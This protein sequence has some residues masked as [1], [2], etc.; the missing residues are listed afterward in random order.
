MVGG[1][2]LDLE[3]EGLEIT[4][5]AADA[6]TGI[7][8][9]VLFYRLDAGNW[10]QYGGPYTS[11]PISFDTA[12]TGLAHSPSSPACRGSPASFKRNVFL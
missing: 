3:A 7:A 5:R 4:F 8:H 10:T 12:A 9:V 1:Q 6:E 11:G 2:V